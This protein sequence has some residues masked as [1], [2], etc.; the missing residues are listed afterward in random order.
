[1]RKIILT[2]VFFNLILKTFSQDFRITGQVNDSIG[3][4]MPGAGISLLHFSDSAL[5]KGTV[6]D[7]NGNFILNKVS[8]GK[9]FLKISFLGYNDLFIIKEIAN[10]SLSLGKLYLQNK[11]STL[12]AVYITENTLPVQL[13][14]DTTQFN[15]D[16]FKTNRDAS[17][18]DLATKMPGI[19]S[20]DG[21]IQAQ[22]E[23]VKKVL[24]DG[25]PFMGDDPNA[26]LKNLP[27]EIIEK[28]QVFDKKS[29]QSEFTGFNDG[30]TTKTINIITR[31]QFRNGTFGKAFGGYGTEE[32]WK[33]GLNLNFFKD[34]RKLIILGNVNNINEQNFSTDDLLGTGRS[35]SRCCRSGHR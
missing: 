26:A 27:A 23:D 24:I 13:K 2:L 34:K 6:T 32:L 12:N 21:K 16:A 14:G 3:Q 30:N 10:Q 15:A 4:S 22:G 11:A 28:I 5:I 1:M 29:D 7:L 9:I 35:S 18:E 20:Q 33:G 8:P 31:P 25:K 19:T 17:A